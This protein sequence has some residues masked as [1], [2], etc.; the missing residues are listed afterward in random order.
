MS[1]PAS[2]ARSAAATQSSCVRLM[3][4]SSIA[5]GT[6][7]GSYSLAI[8]LGASGTVR[9]SRP[10]TWMPPC[11]SSTA[12]SAPCECASSAI[13]RS[14]RTSPS[15][16]RRAEMNGY[17]SL[18]GLIEQYSVETDAQPPSALMPRCRACVH[19]F[20]TP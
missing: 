10:S 8:W 20:A 11:Q 14:A 3:S 5:L 7:S 16:H 2:R 1:K 12:A 9:D 6:T 15:S 4:E 13:R 19:G 18:S 17:S